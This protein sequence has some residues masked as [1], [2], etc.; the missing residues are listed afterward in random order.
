MKT[1]N[2][3]F[4]KR[5]KKL[6]PSARG[7]GREDESRG[8]HRVDAGESSASATTYANTIAEIWGSKTCG[9]SQ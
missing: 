4:N 2:H 1:S 8:L 9:D 6:I 3:L 5:Y 7:E